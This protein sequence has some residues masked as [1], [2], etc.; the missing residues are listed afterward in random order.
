MKNLVTLA[1]TLG[2]GALAAVVLSSG[3][4]EAQA[5]PYQYYAVIAL[6]GLRHADRAAVGGRDGRRGHQ[7]GHDPDVPAEEPVRDPQQRDGGLP[8]PDDRDA[9]RTGR[10]PADRSVPGDVPGRFDVELL[11]ERDDRERSDRAAGHRGGPGN[12]SG[13]PGARSGVR[14]DRRHLPVPE[15]VHVSPADRRERVLPVATAGIPERPT[16]GRRRSESSRRLFSY[17]RQS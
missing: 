16:M 14:R 17:S 2:L 7:L 3:L 11:P 15:H 5:G 12:G 1:R 8:E 4:A 6:P 13:L 10:R 9:E